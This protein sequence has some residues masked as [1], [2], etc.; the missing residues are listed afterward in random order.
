MIEN[1]TIVDVIKDFRFIISVENCL[2]S[3]QTYEWMFRV[4]FFFPKN[5]I[6]RNHKLLMIFR[7][8][9]LRFLM[10]WKRQEKMRMNGFICH[11]IFRKH[12]FE[13]KWQMSNHK[14]KMEKKERK[15]HH[16]FLCLEIIHFSIAVFIR[17][18]LFLLEF[19]CLLPVSFGYSSEWRFHCSTFIENEMKCDAACPNS[20][21]LFGSVYIVIENDAKS[22][23]DVMWNRKAKTTIIIIV[24]TF[25]TSIHFHWKPNNTLRTNCF[26]YMLSIRLYFIAPLLPADNSSVE[27][28]SIAHRHIHSRWMVFGVDVGV[29]CWFRAQNDVN[30]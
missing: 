7:L 30:K 26:C 23:R 2:I 11:W 8:L 17:S 14:A 25:N 12:S 4:C 9:R 6:N 29:F 20:S 1:L 24:K 15:K 22:L 19:Y 3:K 18:H 27:D 16:I 10:K 21:A 5:K 28:N 13:P